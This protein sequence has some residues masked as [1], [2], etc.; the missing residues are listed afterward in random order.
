MRL[1]ETVIKEVN[2]SAFDMDKAK[3]QILILL[4]SLSALA[5]QN[6]AGTQQSS[7]AME[8]QSASLQEIAGVSENLSA[9]S[10]DLQ[11]LVMKFK[12]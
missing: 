8:E 1:S 2:S 3:N 4:Q 10:N 7:S 12:A 6:V 9:L 5:E 11:L